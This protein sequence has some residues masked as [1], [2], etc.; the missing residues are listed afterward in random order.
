MNSRKNEGG[1]S[2]LPITKSVNYLHTSE[3]VGESAQKNK[4][5]PDGMGLPL[6]ALYDVILHL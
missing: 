4:G 5:N 3:T 1:N 6:A 2:R